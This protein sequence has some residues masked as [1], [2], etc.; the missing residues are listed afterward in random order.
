MALGA[1]EADEI[2][3]HHHRTGLE[4]VAERVEHRLGGRVQVAVDVPEPRCVGVGGGELG[5]GLRELADVQHAIGGDLRRD[6]AEV[7][8]ALERALGEVLG[9]AAERVEAVDATGDRIGEAGQAAAARDA[10]FGDE[11]IDLGGGEAEAEHLAWQADEALA[12]RLAQLEEALPARALARIEREALGSL[13]RV[14]DAGEHAQRGAQQREL[15]APRA[16]A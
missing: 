7:V 14:G 1:H 2:V 9:Q 16:G 8:G 13:F 11:A 4:P 5:Q 12:A 6:A 10:E 15:A 3:E